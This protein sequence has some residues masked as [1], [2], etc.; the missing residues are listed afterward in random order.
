[1]FN[2]KRIYGVVKEISDVVKASYR[3]ATM[4]AADYALISRPESV[5]ELNGIYY[6]PF[7]D[8]LKSKG[9]TFACLIE[10]NVILTDDMFDQLSDNAKMF[11]LLH[12][13]GHKE[14][15]HI[16]FMKERY[17]SAQEVVKERNAMV[18]MNQVQRYELEADAYALNFMSAQEVVDAI[19]EVN[20]VSYKTYYA[21]NKELD[22][23]KEVMM[24]K[25]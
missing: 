25:L 24:Q 6:V 20:Q 14:N 15:N 17:A 21:R 13:L 23:R 8:M 22:L 7:N 5:K 4:T 12:E 16:E 9:Y 19:E 10:G 18:K 3:V 11:L 2:V 1:M